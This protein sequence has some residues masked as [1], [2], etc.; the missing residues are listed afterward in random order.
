MDP[1]VTCTELSR[2]LQN[3]D[4][5]ARPLVID[6]RRPPAFAAAPDFIKGALRRDPAA[7]ADWAPVLPPHREVVVYCVHGHEVSQGAARTLREAGVDSRYLEHG[8][9]GWREGGGA[10]Y[11]KPSGASTAWIT[12]ARPK[13]DRIACP[14][15]VARLIDRDA[16]FLYVPAA[17]VMHVAVEKRA[18]PF[19]VTAVELGHHG[20]LCSFDAFVAAFGLGDEPMRKLAAIVRAAD[21][22]KPEAVPEASGLLA[23]SQ[24]LSLNYADDHAMLARGMDVYDALYAFCGGGRVA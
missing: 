21:V 2:K 17:E 9:E 20:E 4:P 16:Q 13:I 24:G 6:V 19:D 11:P 14:W 3:A 18:I 1:T 7:V 23:V 8:I 22:G 15:L 10:L 5:A 12:R